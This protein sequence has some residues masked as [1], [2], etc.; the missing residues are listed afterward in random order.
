MLA[1]MVPPSVGVGLLPNR[2]HPIC[3]GCGAV[4][5]KAAPFN[6][7]ASLRA[8]PSGI[9]AAITG[10]LLHCGRPKRRHEWTVAPNLLNYQAP[11]LRGL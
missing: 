2:H 4:G 11:T 8:K 5:S 3:R 9:A 10:V 1:L 6:L 7:A